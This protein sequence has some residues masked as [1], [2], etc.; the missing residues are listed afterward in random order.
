MEMYPKRSGVFGCTVGSYY[1]RIV[2]F[3]IY[4]LP[5]AGLLFDVISNDQIESCLIKTNK[6][7]W[8]HQKRETNVTSVDVDKWYGWYF[9]PT[10]GG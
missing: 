6:Q 10:L 3:N 7:L 9:Q 2:I 4:I 8:E 1:T 5:T